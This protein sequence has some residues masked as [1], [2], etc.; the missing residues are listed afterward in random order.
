VPK[1]GAEIL[2][3]CTPEQARAA[4]RRMA[5]ADDIAWTHPQDG[6]YSRAHLMV[7]RLR[8]LGYRPG[9]VWAFASGQNLHARTLHDPQGYIEWWWHVAPTLMVKD[10][11]AIR[12]VVIDPSLFTRPVSLQRWR[13]SMKKTPTSRDPFICLTRLGEPPL[14]VG[15]RRAPG[16]GYWT[17]GDPTNGLDAHARDTMKRYQA[18]A[19]A[20]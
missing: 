18:T 13:D 12:E 15:G 8:D 20:R 7:R 4:F 11:G 17:S 2:D 3:P 9:K 19:D 10:G 6:C 1:V 5:E 14:Q 16:S